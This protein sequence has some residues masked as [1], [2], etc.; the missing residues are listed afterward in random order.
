[1]FSL[2]VA[3]LCLDSPLSCC[4][5][6][7]NDM[8]SCS[9]KGRARSWAFEHQVRSLLASGASARAAREQLLQSARAF[10]RPESAAA[11]SLLVSNLRWFQ[12]QREA[13]GNEAWLY[14]M[15][16]L[17][18]AQEC[19]Q[20]GFDET[21]IDGTPTLN[22]WVLLHAGPNLPPRVVTIQCAGL[23]VGSTAAEIARHIEGAWDVGQHA[24]TL[25]RAELGAEADVLVPMNNGGIQLH[26]LRGIMHD[27]CAT[28]NL[29]AVF[30]GELR[31]ISGQ[32]Q[33]GY[34]EWES[35]AKGDKPWFDF[36]CANHVRNLPID[37]FNRLFEEYIKTHLGVEL[38]QISR[39]GNGRTRVEASG[40]LLLRSLCRLIHK[41][42]HQ[43][44]KGD[45]HRFE[46]WLQAKYN[47]EIKNRCAGRAEFSKRQDW[48]VEASWKFHNLIQPI[49]LYCIETLVLDANILRDSILTRIEQIRFLIPSSTMNYP[50]Y[51]LYASIP[52]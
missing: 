45:G 27:T 5:R 42:H 43:Y 39:D 33:F 48:C 4:L 23:L 11:Y 32:L 8:L 26:K 7:V 52:L 22:Q 38:A 24:I 29:A 3:M 31:D 41:G 47:G 36:L 9:G 34:D 6:T 46:D 18:R 2:S 12:R 17:S 1:M 35:K 37:E 49:N 50:F 15:I 25:L 16:E 44:A 30:I 51:T 10:L 20:H 14:G 13:L 28:A 40:L 19:L 21:S